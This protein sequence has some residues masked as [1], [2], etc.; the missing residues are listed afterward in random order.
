[1]PGAKRW[2]GKSIDLE[3]DE[4]TIFSFRQRGENLDQELAHPANLEHHVH[5]AAERIIEREEAGVG[6][7][8]AEIQAIQEGT[9]GQTWRLEPRNPDCFDAIEFERPVLQG[10]VPLLGDGI[11]ALNLRDWHYFDSP[12]KL[13]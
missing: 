5:K 2:S 4:P 1:V 11:F 8:E 3:D 10:H 9:L 13:N 12:E 6:I 7:E